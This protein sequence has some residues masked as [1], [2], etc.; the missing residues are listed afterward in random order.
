MSERTAPTELQIKTNDLIRVGSVAWLDKNENP[1]AYTKFGEPCP[2]AGRA[3]F[4]VI[5]PEDYDRAIQ[6]IQD[7][8]L[9][10]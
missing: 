10:F 2:P 4:I 7:G 5:N 1:F 8:I 3:G 6:A 9:T